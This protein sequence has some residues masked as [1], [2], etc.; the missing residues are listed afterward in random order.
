MAAMAHP[1]GKIS[2]L[3]RKKFGKKQLAKDPYFLEQTDKLFQDFSERFSKGLVLKHTNQQ[4]FRSPE[5]IDSKQKD[6]IISLAYWMNYITKE[7]SL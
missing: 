1:L 4:L 5:F 3:F 7:Y 2:V 6:K